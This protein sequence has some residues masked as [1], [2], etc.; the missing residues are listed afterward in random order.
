MN[1][2]PDDTV[3]DETAPPVRKTR[4]RRRDPLGPDSE[5]GVRLRELYE[6]TE[7]EPI[8]SQL[9]DLLEKLAEAERKAGK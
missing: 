5:I 4:A 9:I 1:T 3:D 2:V 6:E 8:P 7:Q